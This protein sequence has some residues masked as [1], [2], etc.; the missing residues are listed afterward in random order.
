MRRRSRNSNFT[1]YEA[2]NYRINALEANT[3]RAMCLP[4][5]ITPD[6]FLEWLIEPD[7]LSKLRAAWQF[8][9]S[10]NHTD[11]TPA[12]R[13]ACGVVTFNID[14]GKLKCLAPDNKY[15]K[16]QGSNDHMIDYVESIGAV[17]NQ[18]NKLR[19]IITEFHRQKVTP[20]AAKYYFPT[21][22][23]LLP[24]DH[25]FHKATGER[26][27]SFAFPYEITEYLREAPEII[28]KGLLCGGTTAFR[29]GILLIQMQIGDGQFFQLCPE[30]A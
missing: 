6:H 2:A 21:L 28:G 25:P 11:F 3:V 30:L 20:G 19:R 10:R 27:R 13:F 16:P 23:P 9:A 15:V 4:G 29:R 17:A 22:Q 24:E 8:T 1:L 18:Y 7:I 14:Y 12:F 26:H 5:D